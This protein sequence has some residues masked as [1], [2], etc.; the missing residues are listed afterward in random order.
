MYFQ[1]KSSTRQPAEYQLTYALEK[2]S[3][4]ESEDSLQT[5]IGLLAQVS[6]MLA[7]FLQE[8]SSSNVAD[9]FRNYLIRMI[10]EEKFIYEVHNSLN[11]SLN[12]SLENVLANYD[13]L[14]NE[15]RSNRSQRALSNI[16][17]QIHLVSSIPVIENQ[18]DAVWS[19]HQRILEHSQH[20]VRTDKSS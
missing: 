19:Y 7:Y 8:N 2:N 13:Q 5:Q 11:G 17:D 12:T 1:C 4:K 14:Y 6:S 9:P 3:N 20:V 10:K 18:M 16:Y 15:C